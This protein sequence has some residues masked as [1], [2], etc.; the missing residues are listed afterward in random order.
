MTKSQAISL[1]G[2]RQQDLADAVGVSR[3]AIAQWPEDL[4][5]R[6]IDIVVGAAY[7]LGKLPSDGRE[8]DSATPARAA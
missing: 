1:F 7:R 6:Q 4:P 8:Q 2:T 5:Q 3:S